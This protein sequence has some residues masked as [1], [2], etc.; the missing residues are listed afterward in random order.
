M[1]ASHALILEL[2]RL[3]GFRGAVIKRA[4]ESSGYPES[5]LPAATE[6][7]RLTERLARPRWVD[8]GEGR[9]SARTLIAHYVPSIDKDG[10]VGGVALLW[11]PRTRMLHARI[12]KAPKNKELLI[13]GFVER[14]L[15][16]GA[17][18]CAR[19]WE[20]SDL[21]KKNKVIKRYTADGE[22][23]EARPINLEYLPQKIVWIDCNFDGIDVEDL[24]VVVLNQEILLVKEDQDG[25]PNLEPVAVDELPHKGDYA[26]FVEDLV[27]GF[28]IAIPEWT[29]AR[30]GDKVRGMPPQK[31]VAKR[32]ELKGRRALAEL[33]TIRYGVKK[34]MPG[35]T[36][37]EKFMRDDAAEKG[38]ATD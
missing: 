15:S 8:V 32:L 7:D 38:K 21:A 4:L 23:S 26:H 9:Q 37:F 3:T 5:E 30:L 34:S 24:D 19:L 1:I 31:S 25:N 27:N 33:R 22:R 11:D 29:I 36:L 17:Q 20:V 14:F 28:N 2:G 12:R 16:R 13:D 6:C 18:R 10:N 35:P